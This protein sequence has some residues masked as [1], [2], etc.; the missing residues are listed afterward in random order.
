[1]KLFTTD[2]N[3]MMDIS[4]IETEDSALVIRGTIM[5]VMP[6]DVVLTGR[7]MRAA[8]LLLSGK[9]IWTA[10]RMLFSK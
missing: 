7:E 5:G 3:E 8:I 2:N 10:I 9:V 1:M 4:R 6:I